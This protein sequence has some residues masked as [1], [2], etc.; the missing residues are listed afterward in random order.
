MAVT[1]IIK[2]LQK[3]DVEVGSHAIDKFVEKIKEV[4][5]NE[6][7]DLLESLEAHLNAVTETVKEEL[8]EET[9]QMVK[10]TK[11]KKQKDPNAP[12]RPPTAYNLFVKEKMEELSKQHPEINRQEL[13]KMA[14]A[15]WRKQHPKSDDEKKET[16]KGGKTAAK[17]VSLLSDTE[18]EQNDDADSDAEKPSPS[19]DDKKSK[20]K[21]GKKGGK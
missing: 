1:D 9:K 8:K 7:V 15:I 13:M 14:V 10:N 17:P 2:A 21:K 5:T 12:K 3:H 19:H 4:L 11:G 6:D 20:S 18:P 16:K